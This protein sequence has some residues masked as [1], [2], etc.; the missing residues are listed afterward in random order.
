MWD[1]RLIAAIVFLFPA[2]LAF[3]AAA[4]GK[5]GLKNRKMTMA[6]VGV[7][8]LSTFLFI[9]LIWPYIPD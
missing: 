9:I 4:V 5:Y 3:P 7:G 6:A 1:V 2:I 8:V